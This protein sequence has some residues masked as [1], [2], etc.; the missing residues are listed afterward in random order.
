M[1]QKLN[2]ILLVVRVFEK[3][4]TNPTYDQYLLVGGKQK[5][6]KK[7]HVELFYFRATTIAYK[8]TST[9]DNIKETMCP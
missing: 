2:S 3:Q 1:S 8:T 6:G 4:K 9:K 5:H 7:N